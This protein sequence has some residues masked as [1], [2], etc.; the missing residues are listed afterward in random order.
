MAIN[1]E[2]AKSVREV[3]LWASSFLEKMDKEVSAANWIFK[4]R[5]GLTH[6]DLVLNYKKSVSI[7]DKIQFKEDIEKFAQDYPAQYIVG[8]EWFYD[9]KFRVTESTLIPRPET[10]EWFDRYITNLPSRSLVTADI[11]TGS[12]VLA[13]SHKLERPGDTVYGTDISFGA[14]EQAQTNAENLGAE[15]SFLQGDLL[16]PL[17]DLTFD[18][19]VSNPPYISQNE[20]NEMDESVRQNEPKQAL[21]AEDNGLEVYKHLAAELPAFL[22]E[23]GQAYIEIGYRQGKAVEEIFQ[24]A[25]PKSEVKIWQDLSGLDRVIYIQK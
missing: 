15:V 21:F 17:K 20:W 8:H 9:R 7:K 25:F 11:G 6:T 19:I 5:F 24:Q 1:F 3:L 18:L 14:L 10:E 23:K 4:E 22:N 12:G 2:E 13:V 16:E